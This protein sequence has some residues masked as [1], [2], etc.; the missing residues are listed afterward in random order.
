M[1]SRYASIIINVVQLVHNR[2]V[3]WAI[4][5]KPPCVLRRSGFCSLAPRSRVWRNK[6]E[7]HVRS[8]LWLGSWRGFG[9]T[10]FNKRP[11][12]AAG[13]PKTFHFMHD[14]PSM[15][16]RGWRVIVTQLLM[17]SVRCSSLP[18]Q[19]SC[20][21]CGLPNQEQTRAERSD[22]FTDKAAPRGQ[23]LQRGT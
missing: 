14:S 2:R 22:T 10:L 19:W 13:S 7:R 12:Q 23:S 15:E 18:W 5:K 17:L 16:Q 20:L 6:R 11:A 1:T 4:C 21:H 3:P 8:R 9:H